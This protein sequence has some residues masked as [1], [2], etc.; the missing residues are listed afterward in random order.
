MTIII[1]IMFVFVLFMVNLTIRLCKSAKI[2]DEQL[3][4]IHKE[5][6]L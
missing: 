1:A 5:L 2:A 4:E 6:D 3:D